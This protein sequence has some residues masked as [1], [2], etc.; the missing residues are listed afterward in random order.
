MAE[1]AL[2]LTTI[3]HEDVWLYIFSFLDLAGQSSC[4]QVCKAWG[5][6]ARIAQIVRPI[7]AFPDHPASIR[8]RVTDDT[9]RVLAQRGILYT[10]RRLSMCLLTAITDEG[11]N[12][13]YAYQL[14]CAFGSSSL[15]APPNGP[16]TPAT[17]ITT[18]ISLTT[19]AAILPP[20]SFSSFSPLSSLDVSGCKKLTPQG[21]RNLIWRSHIFHH[22]HHKNQQNQHPHSHRQSQQ[23]HQQV[24]EQKEEGKHQNDHY[25]FEQEHKQPQQRSVTTLFFESPFLS[26]PS[27]IPPL[28]PSPFSPTSSTLLTTP[29]STSTISSPIPPLPA[30]RHLN[31]SG[32]RK[33]DNKGCK[34]LRGVCTH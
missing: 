22:H 16:I 27:T 10:C 9:L 14:P 31:L 15:P 26:T 7:V 23:K 18:P 32:I 11:I 6:H 19:T 25:N 3:L 21:I 33:L 13:L 28:P 24:R 2:K 34:V 30:L 12:H 17:K 29:T 5:H 4:Q 20:S 8:K 1:I